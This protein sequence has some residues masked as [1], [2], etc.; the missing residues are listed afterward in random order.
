MAVDSDLLRAWVTHYEGMTERLFAQISSAHASYKNRGAPNAFELLLEDAE[1]WLLTSYKP[2]QVAGLARRWASA[3]SLSAIESE[4]AE[5]IRTFEDS[6]ARLRDA[7][8]IVEHF[9]DYMRGRGGS[10]L[11]WGIMV[12]THSLQL[13]VGWCPHTPRHEECAALTRLDLP[14][15]QAAMVALSRRTTML[16][17]SVEHVGRRVFLN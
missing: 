12:P 17:E 9:D 5:A 1:L 7:R 14:S 16:L 8:N 11:Q 6:T 2:R 10:P 3:T 15:T 4:L 13:V